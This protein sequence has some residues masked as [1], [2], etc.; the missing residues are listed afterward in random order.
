MRRQ[1]RN[2]LGQVGRDEQSLEELAETITQWDTAVEELS[3]YE[4]EQMVLRGE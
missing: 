2:T 4:Y 1:I 3:D